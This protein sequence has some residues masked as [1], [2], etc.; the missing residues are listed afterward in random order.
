MCGKEERSGRA[1]AQRDRERGGKKSY[2]EGQERKTTPGGEGFYV[3]DRSQEC[4]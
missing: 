3:G 1:L 2:S 4:Y